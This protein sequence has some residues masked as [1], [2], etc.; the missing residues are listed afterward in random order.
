MVP[1]IWAS[2]PACAHFDP[3]GSCTSSST[4]AQDLRHAQVEGHLLAPTATGA[5]NGAGRSAKSRSRRPI[6]PSKVVRTGKI[7]PNARVWAAL[8]L[9]LICD[10]IAEARDKTKERLAQVGA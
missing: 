2:T 6:G 3:Q 1:D 9:L 5:F 10:T 4:H 7:W 8:D